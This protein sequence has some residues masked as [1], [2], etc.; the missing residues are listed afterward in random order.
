[1]SVTSMP[2]TA[3]ERRRRDDHEGDTCR[4]V[5]ILA[6]DVD[7]DRHRQDRAAAAQQAEAQADPHPKRYCR[8][9][10]GYAS[11]L[12]GHGQPGAVPGDHPA[13][14]IDRVV[15]GLEGQTRGA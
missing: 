12:T 2:D 14:H 4:L 3:D 11:P 10:H 5:D 9:N 13:A 1:V 15:S 8:Q 7:D 6:E